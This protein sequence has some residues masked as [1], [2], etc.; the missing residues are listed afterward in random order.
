MS[1]KDNN[2]KTE[3]KNDNAGRTVQLREQRGYTAPA[4]APSK[5]PSSMMSNQSDG[6]KK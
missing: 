2:K 5:P 1:E 6:K 4:P 3:I